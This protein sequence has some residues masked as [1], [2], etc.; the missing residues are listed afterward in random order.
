MD[1]SDVLRSSTLL[2]C[3]FFR[4]DCSG[5]VRHGEDVRVLHHRPGLS[6]PGESCDSGERIQ[7]ELIGGMKK[8]YILYSHQQSVTLSL[9]ASSNE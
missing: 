3:L 6:G 9:Q 5:Q 1:Y 2:I 8:M 7:P 4:F